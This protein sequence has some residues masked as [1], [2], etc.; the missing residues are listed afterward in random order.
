MKSKKVVNN[1]RKP[2]TG[3]PDMRSPLLLPANAAVLTIRNLT[4]TVIRRPGHLDERI[5]A[6]RFQTPPIRWKCVV[7]PVFYH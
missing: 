7:N 2:N 3:R 5:D 1:R 4:P 6:S